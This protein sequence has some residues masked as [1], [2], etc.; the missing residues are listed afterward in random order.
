MVGLHYQIIR[1]NHT[2]GGEKE[3]DEDELMT[4]SYVAEANDV[5]QF[6]QELGAL[7]DKLKLD[8][9]PM[10]ESA[11]NQPQTGP[12]IS[13]GENLK[14]CLRNCQETAPN[15]S[16]KLA[17]TQSKFGLSSDL[18]WAQNRAQPSPELVPNQP[19]N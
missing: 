11:Q 6:L 16:S 18:T 2:R 8:L 4:G 9:K 7:D 1:M 15:S 14:K 3:N 12:K 13:Q 19:R 5:I 17:L 10:Q